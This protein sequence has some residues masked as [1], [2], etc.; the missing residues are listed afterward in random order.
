MIGPCRKGSWDSHVLLRPT[1]R[2][3]KE[4]RWRPRP[5][6]PGSARLPA[7]KWGVRVR[8]VLRGASA[9]GVEEKCRWPPVRI[10][11]VAG[12]PRG[13]CGL[14]SVGAVLGLRGQ[15][16]RVSEGRGL[17]A[18]VPLKVLSTHPDRD[19]LSPSQATAKSPEHF[20]SH[21]RQLIDS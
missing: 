9:L 18:V 6:Q 8:R 3:A 15:A 17:C 2:G 1:E 4:E 11:G 7:T 20:P 12:C 16:A 19:A 21:F 14:A 5:P 13:V 10:L